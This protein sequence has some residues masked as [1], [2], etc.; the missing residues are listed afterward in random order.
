MWVTLKNK[1]DSHKPIPIVNFGLKRPKVSIFNSEAMYSGN[2]LI[3]HIQGRLCQSIDSQYI[4]GR[5]TG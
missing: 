5:Y 4:A 2:F 3:R 1:G